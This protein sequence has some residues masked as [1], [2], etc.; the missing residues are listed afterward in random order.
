MDWFWKRVSEKAINRTLG[1]YVAIL[2]YFG[3][4]MPAHAFFAAIFGFFKALTIVQKVLLVVGIV[5]GFMAAKKAKK[6]R[7]QALERAGAGIGGVLVNKAGTSEPIPVVYGERIVGGIRT[8]IKNQHKGGG[9]G[10]KN[11]YLHIVLTVA[12][13][14]VQGIEE[15]Y[16]NDTLVATSTDTTGHNDNSWTYESTYGDKT[17]LYFR[18]GSQTSALTFSGIHPDFDSTMIGRDI[19][20]LYLRLEFD[21]DLFGSGIP[22]IRCKIK[23]KK[24]PAIGS[25]QSSSLAWTDEPAR[26][27]YDYLTNTRYG[28]GI[29]YTLIDSTSFNNAATYNNEQVDTSASDSTQTTRYKLNGFVDT[30][31]SMLDNTE[32][33]LQACRAGLITGDT[34][35]IF[36]DKPTTAQTTVIDDDY[37]VDSISFQQTSRRDMFNRMK[38]LFPNTADLNGKEDVALVEST[39]LQGSS[40]DDAVL[41]TQIELPHTSDKSMAERIVNEEI[42]SSRQSATLQITVTTRLLDYT[43]G[44]VVKFTN[45]TLGQTEKLYRIAEQKIKPDFNIQLTLREYD[46]NVYWDNN[47]GII[48]DNFNDTDH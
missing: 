28:K 19:A 37:V 2:L 42:N 40:Y 34:Y 20:F 33:L 7:Q 13:G 29:P 41:E 5:G 12:E 17:L 10:N 11:Q 35:K 4:T 3:M 15:V 44:D 36:Q 14:P 26:V 39:T 24:V 48:T 6:K 8:F 9:D 47:T 27:I 1:I 45:G 22:E 23:G 25:S 21:D 43:V 32:D 16:F 18:D 46:A 38:A 31:R 30:S